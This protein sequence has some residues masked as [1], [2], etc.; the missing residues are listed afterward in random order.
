MIL[1]LSIAVA[2]KKENYN[3]PPTGGDKDAHG[4]IGSAGQEWCEVRN[5]C[6]RWFSAFNLTWPIT[7]GSFTLN[8]FI[9]FDVFSN[10]QA[11]KKAEAKFFLNNNSY[12]EIMNYDTSGGNNYPT[13]A[14]QTNTTCTLT[15]LNGSYTFTKDGQT[16]ASNLT[17]NPNP[18]D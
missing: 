12:D 8:N 18:T 11:P 6:L 4:C 9:I 10:N 1:A 16:V 17:I 5:K 7:A 13:S 15:L 2:C 14:K 3:S